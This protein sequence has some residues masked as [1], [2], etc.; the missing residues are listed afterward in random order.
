VIRRHLARQRR[1]VVQARRT[2]SGRSRA[3]RPRERLQ[4][5]A[6]ASAAASSA[7]PITTKSAPATNA[8]AAWAGSRIPPPTSR[9]T[10][11]AIASR[12]AAI[13]AAGTGRA[14]PEPAS[15]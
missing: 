8:A 13:T 6:P 7:L 2:R 9:G 15:R 10:S 14:A 5:R 1:E 4:R 3:H 12:H 11:G